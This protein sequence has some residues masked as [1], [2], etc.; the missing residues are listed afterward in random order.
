MHS[1]FKDHF[2]DQAGDYA[3]YRPRYPEEL[4]DFI[5]DRVGERRQAWDCGTGNGQA[6]VALARRFRRVIATDA[7]KAQISHA[8]PAPNVEYRVAP[9]ERT[10]LEDASVDLITVAQALHWFDFERFYVEVRRVASPRAR[11]SAWGY[12]ACQVNPRID[13]LLDT[14]YRKTTGPYWPPERRHVRDRYATIPFPYHAE[15]APS[16]CMQVTWTASEMLGYLSTWSAVHRCIRATA[17]NPVED[18][19]PSLRRLWA[20]SARPVR[21]PIYLKMAPVFR[22][23]GSAGRPSE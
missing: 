16:F 4:Y 17:K 7:S 23:P 8:M 2:S 9:A 11:L 13:A 6:A 1:H 15:P 18:L 14:F 5:C 20:E 22:S 19:A 21:W 12:D 3:R 10:D